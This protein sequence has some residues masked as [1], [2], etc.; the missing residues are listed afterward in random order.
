MVKYKIELLQLK[1]T[2]AKKLGDLGAF[3][4]HKVMEG[5]YADADKDEAFIKIFNEIKKIEI[6]IRSKE[7]LVKHQEEEGVIVDS[8]NES[9][10]TKE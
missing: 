8:M 6:D 1:R 5:Q 2:Y 3:T 9:S 7:E 10:D 4:Y